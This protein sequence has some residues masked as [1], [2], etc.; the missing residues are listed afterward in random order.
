MA[1]ADLPKAQPT[2]QKWLLLFIKALSKLPLYI[3]FI[4]IK[5]LQMATSA[6]SLHAWSD[7]SHVARVGVDST[8]RDGSSQPRD[9]ENEKSS[10][11][12]SDSKRFSQHPDNFDVYCANCKGLIEEKSVLRTCGCVSR[13]PGCKSRRSNLTLSCTVAGAYFRRVDYECDR[14]DH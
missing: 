7:P 10:L 8:I 2:G 9:T 11:V 13:S 6:P 14:E 3:R 4:M 12:S 5:V 1:R